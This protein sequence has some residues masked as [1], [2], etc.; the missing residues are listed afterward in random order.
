[1]AGTQYLHKETLVWRWHFSSSP[2]RGL[3]HQAEMTPAG[4]GDSGAK[5][6][7]QPCP[8]R[9]LSP[10]FLVGMSAGSQDLQQLRVQFLVACVHEGIQQAGHR[11][12]LPRDKT[13]AV[14]SVEGNGTGAT[15]EDRTGDVLRERQI[16]CTGARTGIM[17]ACK[18]HMSN[19]P[20]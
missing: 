2:Y 20:V 7:S 8:A 6:S 19:T 3:G 13:A 14:A 12:C 1:M 18:Q 5:L 15:F 17:M 16:H 9:S 10:L 11:Q 4:K